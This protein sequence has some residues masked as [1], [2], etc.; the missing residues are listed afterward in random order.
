MENGNLVDDASVIEDTKGGAE[1]DLIEM[2]ADTTENDDDSDNVG[3]ENPPSSDAS[4]DNVGTKLSN[5][6]DIL[7]KYKYLD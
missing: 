1:G 3:H 7:K 4:D 5:I 6:L 2:M